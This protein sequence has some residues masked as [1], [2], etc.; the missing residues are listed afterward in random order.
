M[1]DHPCKTDLAMESARFRSRGNELMLL[2]MGSLVYAFFLSLLAKD[3][4]PLV[5]SLP[6]DRYPK[7]RKR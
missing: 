2:L 5:Q 3:S 4:V 1:Y 7:T 6:Q